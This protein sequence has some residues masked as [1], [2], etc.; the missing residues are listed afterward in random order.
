VRPGRFRPVDLAREH[1]LSTQAVRNYENAGILPPAERTPSGYR[2]YT[3]RHAQAL[4]TFTALVPAH[5]HHTATAVM[6]AVN[7]GNAEHALTLIDHSHAQLL[8]DR[9]ILAAVETALR[10]L[11]R[12][13]PPDPPPSAATFIGPLARQL[14]IRPATL[15]KWEQAGLV[16]PQ[17]DPQTGYRVYAPADVRDAHLAH[18]LRRGGY[19]LRQIAPLLSRVRAAGGVEPLRATLEEW[20]GRLTTRGRAMLT[21]A[22]ALDTYLAQRGTLDA[23]A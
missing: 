1:G 19:L 13:E 2:V 10:D 7:R 6:Q 15:R 3:A 5:G 12:P 21:G 4:R 22:A 8:A 14:G 20:R 18:Q 23:T 17:R 9:Q 16:H 11:A